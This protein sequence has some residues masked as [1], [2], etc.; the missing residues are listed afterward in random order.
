VPDVDRIWSA[1][2]LE[3]LTRTNAR[4]DQGRVRVSGLND[5]PRDLIDRARRSAD[6]DP[7][8][9]HAL[10]GAIYVKGAGPGDT[11]EID[12]LQMEH[13][14]WGWSGRMPTLRVVGR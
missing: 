11:L 9:A 1:A 7:S 2:E 10:S 12:I 14:G 13:K 6:A 4:H 3:A 5:V 8:L